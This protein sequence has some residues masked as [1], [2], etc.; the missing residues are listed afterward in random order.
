MT[1]S[2]SRSRGT[3]IAAHP[4]V[5]GV[6]DFPMR[7]DYTEPDDYEYEPTPHDD[8]LEKTKRHY[9]GDDKAFLRCSRMGRLVSAAPS[10]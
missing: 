7:K 9:P 2:A 4:H 5:G 10:G 8:I 6:Q 1:S 3:P